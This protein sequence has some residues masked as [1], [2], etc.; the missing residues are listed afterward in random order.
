M[1]GN[2]TKLVEFL[3]KQDDGRLFELTEYKEKRSLSAN[4][5]FHV[6]C[7]KIS[8]AECNSMAYTK[9]ELIA[10]Y[11][12]VQYLANGE[13]MVYQTP[14][15]TEYMMELETIHTKCYEITAENGVVFYKYRV[16]RGSHTYNTEE[17]AK[18]IE[19]TI[20]RASQLGIETLTPAEIAR[21]YAQ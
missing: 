15:P 3:S 20:Y 11:G 5:Y 1:I 12:Q 21:L 2:K 9:N 6:L 13:Q 16:Y 18:L 7:D 14:A 4:A 10:Q 8:K 17:M 19:G